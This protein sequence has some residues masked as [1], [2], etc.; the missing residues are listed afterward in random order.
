MV[1]DR[2]VCACYATSLAHNR[3]SPPSLVLQDE[4]ATAAELAAAKAAVNDA[5]SKGVPIPFDSNAASVLLDGSQNAFLKFSTSWCGHCVKMQPDWEK[6]AN[7]VHKDF[8][9]CR[10]VSVGRLPC[11]TSPTLRL[12]LLLLLLPT[13]YP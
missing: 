3:S 4:Q 9:G 5:V 1:D 2:Y 8:K 6:L 7:T 13:N 10:V 11:C 12:L